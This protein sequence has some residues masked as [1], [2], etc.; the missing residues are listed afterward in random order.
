MRLR[1]YGSEVINNKG[2]V[3]IQNPN[4][5]KAYL[6]LLNSFQYAKPNYRHANDVNVVEDFLAGETAMLIS[7]PGFLTE[8]SD[9][10]K[11]NLIGSI[12]CSYIPGRSP[13][14]GG[15]SLGIS[16]QSKV[17]AEAFA[18]LQW[19]CTEQMSNYFS[20]LGTYSAVTSTYTNDEL[21][22]LYPWRPLY[23]EVYPNAAPMLPANSKESKLLSPNDVDDIV[24]KWLYSILDGN[25]DIDGILQRTQ[26]ELQALLG[27]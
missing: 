1:A 9:L 8:V 18:F 11:N 25:D 7:Y 5:R 14:L 21:V 10:R 15:W 17:S 26:E 2:K 6:N 16:R 4:A 12:G 24:C 27:E 3:V 23:Q 20:M 22:Q 19:A 13:L